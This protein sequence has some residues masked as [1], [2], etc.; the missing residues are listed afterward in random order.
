[1]GHTDPVCALILGLVLFCFLSQ[2]PPAFVIVFH[3]N[4][5]SNRLATPCGRMSKM[6]RDISQTIIEGE[7][8]LVMSLME[9]KIVG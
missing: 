7:R 3:L 2:F 6:V 9:M 8:V 1:M 4:R 5:E